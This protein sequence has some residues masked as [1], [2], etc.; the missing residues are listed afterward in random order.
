VSDVS[1]TQHVA[2]H[3]RDLRAQRRWS[4]R[5]L[6]EE[7]VRAGVK[8]LTRGTIAKIESGVR[9]HVTAEEL[10]VL[11][12][13]LGVSP[14]VLLGIAPIR[15]DRADA[16]LAE[17]GEVPASEATL[18]SPSI[19]TSTLP[20]D[21]ESFTGR[22]AELAFVREA[23]NAEL[24]DDAVRVYLVVGMPGVG[25]T[26][27]AVHAAHTLASMFPDGQIFMSL[28][29]HAPGQRPVDPADALAS[30][31]LTMGIRPEQ[32]PRGLE[33]RERLWRDRLSGKRILLVLDDAAATQQVLPLL[34]GTP[35]CLV[36]ITSRR[37]LTALTDARLISLDTLSSDESARLFTRL[38]NRPNL[39]PADAAVADAARLCGYLPLAIGLVAG[40][41]RQH[42]AWTPN[43]LTA[44]LASEQDR[45]PRMQ[46]EH[47]SL[48][49]VFEASYRNLDAD[50]QRLF[51][52]LG[53]HPGTEIDGWA[54]AA[55]GDSDI[56]TALR[57][58]DALYDQHLLDEPA[59]GR[60]R[61]HDLIREYAR[62]LAGS[63]DLSAERD[64]ALERLL[65][66]YLHT[67]AAASRYLAR[68]T[69]PRPLDAQGRRPAHFPVISSRQHAAAWMAVERLNLEAA[70]G[71]AAVHGYPAHAVAIPATMHGFLR[72]TGHW[73][74]ALALHQAALQA[75]EGEG[76]QLG[77][78]AAL[79]DLAD[80][81]YLTGSYAAA[82]AS[83]IHALDLSRVIGNRLA[84]ANALTQLGVLQQA[85]GDFPGAIASLD[86]A[87]DLSRSYG[88]RLGEASAR[89]N[90]GIA[91]FLSGNQ[92]AAAASQQQALDI[93][94][95]LENE[96]GEASALNSLGG[97]QQATGDYQTATD[98]F[99]Q[100]LGRYRSL[101][102]RI[103][104]AYATSNLG[105]VQCITGDYPAAAA[106]LSRALEIYRSLGSRYGEGDTLNSLGALYRVTGNY[107]AAGDSLTQALHLY[108]G[109]GD[110]LGEAGALSELGALQH[111]SGDYPAAAASLTRAIELTREI[112]EPSDEAEALNNLGDLLLDTSAG[113][114]AHDKYVTALAI[115][116]KIGSPLEEARAREG[117]GRCLLDAGRHTA[118]IEMLQRSLAIYEGIGSPNS[119][120]A[121]KMLE[122][123]GL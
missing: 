90:L 111:A 110:R 31:L 107:Q 114:D 104:E 68:R 71:Y 56:A 79:T 46:A 106:N 86:R 59:E 48:T 97:V 65:D 109:L 37:H 36:F 100:A 10:A 14:S 87:L 33:E 42:P 16:V 5:Q 88:D 15:S 49:A 101:G 60:F 93:F 24:I 23:T 57:V 25:K 70:T 50:E 117:I 82:H 66:Y 73:D 53:S 108:R 11:A 58:M 51:R 38:V 9:K 39:D 6:A 98:S 76:D 13:V 81:Q 7:C 44:R 99:G 121:R 1:V 83:L 29:G 35:G 119:K 32:I 67:A 55:L 102:D 3:I 72:S 19:A 91:Q 63:E 47:L 30:L 118:G 80:V 122:T 115:A 74:Q 61:M 43:D 26:A 77:A 105:A 96:L 18:R 123:L 8:S 94:R 75:A 92:R 20:R 116:T 78:A 112:G 69:P 120:R 85:T 52:L 21:I 89:N 113:A 41:L 54:G 84:E 95:S 62:T 64:A 4:A 2:D 12:Q 40:R 45:L 34:P 28:F 103:G 27:F 17:Q 22:E